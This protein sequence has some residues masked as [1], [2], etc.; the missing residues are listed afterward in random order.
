MLYE[1]VYI[2]I[3]ELSELENIAEVSIVL[4]GVAADYWQPLHRFLFR[5][6][7]NNLLSNN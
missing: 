5:P 1:L 4:P 6:A 2:Q 3:S 7:L